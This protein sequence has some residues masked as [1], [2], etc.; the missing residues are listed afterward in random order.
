MLQCTSSARL[1]AL[2][3]TLFAAFGLSPSLEAQPAVEATSAP[4]IPFGGQFGTPTTVADTLMITDTLTIGELQIH[5]DIEHTWIS[6]VSLDLVSPAGTSLRLHD[7]SGGNARDIRGVYSDQGQPPGTLHTPFVCAVQPAGVGGLALFDGESITGNWTLTAND[8]YPSEDDGVIQAWSVWAFA[9]AAAPQVG[10]VSGFTCFFDS[11]SQQ[12]QFLWENTGPPFGQMRIRQGSSV[13]WSGPGSETSATI[14][15]AAAPEP[16]EFSI[17]GVTPGA[18]PSCRA[19]CLAAFTDIGETE[20]C[21]APGLEFGGE[22]A[23]PITVTDSIF[24]PQSTVI[25]DVNLAVRVPHVWI[26]DVFLDLISPAGTSVRLHAGGG[27]DNDLIE[28]VYSDAGV[29]YDS[30]PFDFGCAMQPSGAGTMASF[31]GEDAEGTWQLTATDNYPALDDGTIESWCLRVFDAAVG[32][33]APA[34]NDLAC[35]PT[36]QPGEIAVSWTNVA[37]Y[38]E[39]RVQVDG[40]LYALLPGT[41]TS[42][43][44]TGVP[45]D[46]TV[47]ITV[48]GRLFGSA[49][50]C[51][52]SCLAQVTLNQLLFVRGDANVDGTVNIADA[53]A[54]LDT[55]FSGGA[56]LD[57]HDAADTNDDEQLNVAD[58]IYLLGFL[59]AGEAPPPLPGDTCGSDPTNPE[60]LTCQSYPGCIGFTDASLAAHVLRRIAYGPTPAELERVLQLGVV[61]YIDEQLAP[62]LIDEASNPELN[63]WLA[64]LPSETDLFYLVAEVVARGMHARRQLTEQLTDFWENHFSTYAWTTI[65]YFSDQLGGDFNR[66]YAEGTEM[67]AL[68]N[69]LFRD[70]AVGDFLTLL[71]T[72]ATSVTMLIYLDS[73]LNAAGIP[74]ENYARELLELHTMGVDNGYTQEDIEEI[75]R[76]FTGWTVCKVAPGSELD[77]FAP[78]LSP[79]STTGVWAFHFDPSRHDYSGKVIFGGTPYA[80]VIPP[81]TPG[82]AQGIDDGFE[83][84]AHLATLPQTAEFVSRKLIQKFVSD[85]VPLALLAECIATWLATDGD[86]R[87][88]TSTILHSPEFLGPAHRW[89]KVRTPLEDAIATVRAVG[90]DSDL[91]AP[92]TALYSLEQPPFH[93]ITPDGYSELGADQ[94]STLRILEM[95]QFARRF[96]DPFQDPQMDVVPLLANA[97]IDLNDAGAVVDALVGQ[98]YPGNFSAIDRELAIDFLLTNDSGAPLPLD[99]AAADYEDR[100]TKLAM[101][102]L[103]YPQGRK[104]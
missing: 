46:Q 99:A 4:G 16:V 26:G 36:T 75:A 20:L 37:P 63:A 39:L 77:P 65:G 84:L 64:A 85:E 22:F 70:G 59:F 23:T 28:V 62:E 82:S 81:R 47:A 76:A 27:D 14:P 52:E 50:S 31:I 38:E 5:V 102:L 2:A 45:A 58:P 51:A 92:L 41:A 60:V 24:Y 35:A 42:V 12:I 15:F 71:E 97:T 48:T 89:N 19:T 73:I 72:S 90:G 91:N 54:L 78:C 79:F 100:V 10:P 7:H 8:T 104:Q 67:E 25:G 94:L 44:L 101:Y 30:V 88:V 43:L 83:V 18:A 13:V 61:E 40:A 49:R 11:G 33:P 6:D 56:G 69:D 29:P 32:N 3:L 95:V 80:L 53:I 74:N 34:V 21:S 1:R 98:I 93:S 66:G 55:L 57:C 87:A 17:E 96:I 68:E 9:A 86:I 103:V